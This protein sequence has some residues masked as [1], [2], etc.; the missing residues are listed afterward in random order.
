[1]EDLQAVSLT[2]HRAETASELDS[3]CLGDSFAN[4]QGDYFLKATNYFNSHKMRD[5]RM[6]QAIDGSANSSYHREAFSK[7]V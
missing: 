1:V 7:D 6:Y 2:E 4:N 3:L 5:L